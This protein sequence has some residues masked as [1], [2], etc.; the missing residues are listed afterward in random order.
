VDFDARLVVESYDGPNAVDAIVRWTNLT[1]KEAEKAV[2]AAGGSLE[3]RVPPEPAKILSDREL[4]EAMDACWPTASKRAAA[5]SSSARKLR[6]RRRRPGAE[7]LH[8][9]QVRTWEKSGAN[10]ARPALPRVL[11]GSGRGRYKN[12][13]SLKMNTCSIGPQFTRICRN[14]WIRSFLI[15][16]LATDPV[17]SYK[18]PSNG[19]GLFL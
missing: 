18:Q 3:Y 5:H 6:P 19:S 8:V 4:K 10:R 14:L 7:P 15:N 12:A 16:N 1:R 13:R 9:V 2:L 17:F 11:A